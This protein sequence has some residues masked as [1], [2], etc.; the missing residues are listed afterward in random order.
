MSTSQLL[1]TFFFFLLV[2][3]TASLVR[4]ALDLEV[5]GVEA[6]GHQLVDGVAADRRA[7]SLEQVHPHVTKLNENLSA[8][9]AG[10]NI[11]IAIAVK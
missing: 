3:Q 1:S 10:R 2:R 7:V 11:Y 9:A 5:V 4:H 6:V 8:G